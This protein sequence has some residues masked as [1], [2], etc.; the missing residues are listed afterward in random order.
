MDDRDRW[1]RAYGGAVRAPQP[2]AVQM[3]DV[4]RRMA[5]ERME[6]GQRQMEDMQRNMQAGQAFRVPPMQGF[7]PLEGLLDRVNPHLQADHKLSLSNPWGNLIVHT[8]QYVRDDRRSKL[9]CLVSEDRKIHR[10][11]RMKNEEDIPQLETDELPEEY[12]RG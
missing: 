12:Q 7:L 3:E 6:A 4:Q 10:Y 9:L 11:K 1:L 5:E 2:H 8:S